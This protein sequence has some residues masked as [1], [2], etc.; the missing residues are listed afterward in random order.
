MTENMEEIMEVIDNL[1]EKI[2]NVSNNV[3][4]VA[5]NLESSDNGKSGSI[6]GCSETIFFI[7]TR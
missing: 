7:K 5:K 3:A 2:K 6:V 1:S 4:N